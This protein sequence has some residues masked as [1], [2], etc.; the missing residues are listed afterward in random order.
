MLQLGANHKEHQGHKDKTN[1]GN[2]F[3]YF[4]HFVVNF[5]PKIRILD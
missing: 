4:V 5:K 3:V 2:F 1:L